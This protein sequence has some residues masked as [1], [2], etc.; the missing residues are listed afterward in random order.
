MICG[1]RI[2]PLPSQANQAHRSYAS[3]ARAGRRSRS[4]LIFLSDSEPVGPVA[5]RHETATS[6]QMLGRH[7]A[8]MLAAHKTRKILHF[9][10]RTAIS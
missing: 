2:E 1:C 10:Y 7:D 3:I 8:I 9:C 5:T 6:G 4:L